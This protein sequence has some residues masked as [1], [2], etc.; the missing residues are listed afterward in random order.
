MLLLYIALESFTVSN[1]VRQGGMLSQ[2]LF[3]VYMDDQSSRIDVCKT[4]CLIPI[5]L[6]N[7]LTYADYLVN[8]C[9]N[10]AGI[11]YLLKIC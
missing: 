5:M 6:V 8:F 7:H 9:P 4:G 11:D 3:N 10:C 2:F 1:G